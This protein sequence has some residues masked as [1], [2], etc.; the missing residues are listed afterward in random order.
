MNL[1][2]Q[3]VGIIHM[4]SFINLCTVTDA[5]VFKNKILVFGVLEIQRM[6]YDFIPVRLSFRV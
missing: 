6:Q 3:L 1:R 5:Y 2:Y 4:S